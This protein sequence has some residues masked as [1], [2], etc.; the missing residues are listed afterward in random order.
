[1]LLPFCLLPLALTLAIATTT[2]KEQ[3]EESKKLTQIV[4]TLR[5]RARVQPVAHSPILDKLAWEKSYAMNLTGQFDHY[6]P[7]LPS[8]KSLMDKCGTNWTVAGENLALQ[9]WRPEDAVQ[10]WFK[11]PTH[12][13]NLLEPRFNAHGSCRIGQY[14]TQ[15][16]GS[17]E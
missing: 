13:A 1:M 8:I 14:Y 10:G 12:K 3:Q 7:N 4:N 5:Q 16:F 9:Y 6:H 17:F 11:S 15:L 2:T